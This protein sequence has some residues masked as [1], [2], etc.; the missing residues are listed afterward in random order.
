M[1]MIWFYTSTITDWQFYWALDF[2]SVSAKNRIRFPSVIK[3]LKIWWYVWGPFSISL[4][5]RWAWTSVGNTHRILYLKVYIKYV[6]APNKP[7]RWALPLYY[8]QHGP[9]DLEEGK[10]GRSC[11]FQMQ[12]SSYSNTYDVIFAFCFKVHFVILLCYFMT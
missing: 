6:T 5:L 3:D 10:R 1:V 11:W 9:V 7:R 8:L 4:S 2:I 12:L